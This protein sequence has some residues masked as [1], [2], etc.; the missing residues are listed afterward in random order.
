MSEVVSG[1]QPQPGRIRILDKAV[2]EAIA[3]GEVIDRPASAVKELIE[4][5]LDAEA[6]TVSVEIEEGG[7]D[8]LRVVDNGEGMTAE[9]LLQ[10][11]DRHATSKLAT[12]DDLLRLR[13]FGF[14]GEALASIA[15]VSR[16][17]A[18]SR[19]AEADRA[20]SMVVEGEGRRG[21]VVTAGPVGT[22]I[23]ARDL[24]HNVP[25]RRAFLRSPRA[26][27]AAVS[28]VLA[29]AALSR[30]DVS[31]TLRSQGRKVLRVAAGGSLG[32]AIAAVY[33]REAAE[34]LLEVHFDDSEVGAR[35]LVGSPQTARPSRNAMVIM[36]NGRRVHHR[37]LVAA[38]EA[39][40]RGLLPA[41]RYPLV[42]LDLRCDP[43]LV[44]VNVHPTKREVRFRDERRMFEVVQRS[45]WAALQGATPTSMPLGPRAT[46][47]PGPARQQL[48]HPSLPGLAHESVW[49][50]PQMDSRISLSEAARWRYLG[51]V[52]SRY[53]VAETGSGVALI[54]QHA[55]HE[56]VLYQRW[57]KV[58][59]EPGAEPLPAQGL[60]QPIL[61]ETDTAAWESAFPDGLTLAQLG[62][63]VDIFGESTVRCSAAPAG[64]RA[65]EV[66]GAL[67]DLLELSAETQDGHAQRHRLAASL[68]CH[69]AVRFGDRLP[70]VEA[71]ALIRELA[72][73]E[74]G[75]SCPHGRPAVLLLS[76]GQLLSAFQRR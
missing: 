14:R 50:G 67:T 40:Y 6:T 72:I 61:I 34:G 26:E 62:F 23:S 55:A 63:E 75:I 31:F 58:L 68:A 76:E 59:A 7:L 57:M 36:V 53:L 49:A 11:F 18:I 10:A 69:S 9:E 4:N 64:M 1:R 32:A 16:V 5:S 25:A 17:T 28:R 29:E 45:C 65:S 70:E 39:A 2:A 43:A 8:L 3:A 12:I 66:T 13:T 24:F 56:K 27:A 60:L 44:D 42:V 33:G 15:A 41:G 37:A 48:P 21:P 52:H 35:G 47:E 51:Q 38:V 74:G 71:A 22:T 46:F 73:T 30:P 54:D 20:H 19:V